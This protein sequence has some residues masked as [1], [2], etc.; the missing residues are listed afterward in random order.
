MS[1]YG[2]LNQDAL[3]GD[4][5][6]TIFEISR[7]LDCFFSIGP[8]LCELTK[9]SRRQKAKRCL[10]LFPIRGQAVG[11]FSILFAPELILYNH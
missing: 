8:V 5:R 3:A 4:Y 11:L 10:L 6:C 9:R 1:N 2:V 7:R